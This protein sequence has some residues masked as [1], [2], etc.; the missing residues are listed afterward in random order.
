MEFLKPLVEASELFLTP[1]TFVLVPHASRSLRRS[2]S[3]IAL[4]MDA[5]DNSRTGRASV[6][7]VLGELNNARIGCFFS[8]ETKPRWSPA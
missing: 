7:W 4:R 2:D 1:L 6:A 3:A 5:E 8:F